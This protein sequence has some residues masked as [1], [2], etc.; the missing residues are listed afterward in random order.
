MRSYP[1]LWLRFLQWEEVEAWPPS[2]IITVIPSGCGYETEVQWRS[3]TFG[4]VSEEVWVSNQHS[5]S[6][7]VLFSHPSIRSRNLVGFHRLSGNTPNPSGSVENAVTI[8]QS[9]HKMVVL[10]SGGDTVANFSS[11]R[12]TETRQENQQSVVETEN[13]L[14]LSMGCAERQFSCLPAHYHRAFSRRILQVCFHQTC[15]IIDFGS[16][17]THVHART[18]T[19]VWISFC[20]FSI[21]QSIE[22]TLMLPFCF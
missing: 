22:N 9:Q 20:F 5:F 2:L 10:I 21:T 19:Y 7:E 13:L 6:L 16:R 14:H 1:G 12:F 17:H 15:F 8:V 3:A 11:M 4:L 18:Y